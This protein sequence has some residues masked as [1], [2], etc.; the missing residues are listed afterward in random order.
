MALGTNTFAQMGLARVLQRL[1][2]AGPKIVCRA[3][4]RD[5]FKDAAMAWVMSLV[6]LFY[7]GLNDCPCDWASLVLTA[8]IKSRL[9]ATVGMHKM[10]LYGA[11][12][13]IIFVG[14]LLGTSL[15]TTLGLNSVWFMVWQFMMHFYTRIAFG[16]ATAGPHGRF[17]GLR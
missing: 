7:S 4:R 14:L 1:D 11:W 3:M 9:V 17:W 2:A 8:L 10:L 15:L 5:R 12:G 13:H 6:L 16:D